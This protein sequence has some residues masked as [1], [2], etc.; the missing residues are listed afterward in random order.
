M[1]SILPNSPLHSVGGALNTHAEAVKKGSKNFTEFTQGTVLILKTRLGF[2]QLPSE[3][4]GVTKSIA[5]R[6]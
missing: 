5:P 2:A 3:V 4:F 1:F 6:L